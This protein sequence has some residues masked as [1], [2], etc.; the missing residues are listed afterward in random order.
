MQLVRGSIPGP[1]SLPWP[2]IDHSVTAPDRVA[3]QQG[4][5]GS[6]PLC[7]VFYMF[8]AVTYCPLVAQCVRAALQFA[9]TAACLFGLGKNV[10]G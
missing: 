4:L 1:G 7:T 9:V 8:G 5:A 3:I 2:E 6:E 10:L